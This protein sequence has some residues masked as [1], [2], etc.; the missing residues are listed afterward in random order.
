MRDVKTQKESFAQVSKNLA[1]LALKNN[2]V[3]LYQNNYIGRS[4]T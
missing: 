1:R 4:S 3:E 2:S